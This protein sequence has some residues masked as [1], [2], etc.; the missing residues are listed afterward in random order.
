[1]D[2][3][4]TWQATLGELELT[5]SKA[6]F[7]T[8][9]KNTFISSLENGRVVISVPNTF[10]KAWL[11]KKYHEPIVKALRNVT[12]NGVREVTY[13]VEVRNTTPLQQFAD[14]IESNHQVEEAESFRVADPS[15]SVPS[16]TDIG[17]NPRYIFPSFVVGKANELAHAAAMAVAAKPGEAYNPL[18]IYGGSGLGKTHLLQAIGHH[19]LESNP[20]AKVLYVTS[21]RFTNE[22]IQAVR[23]GRGKEF[24]DM[25]RNVDVLLI[26]DIQF[27]AGKES[28]QEELFHTFNT[29]HQNNKQLVISSDRAPK[30]IQSL[31]TRMLTRF[32]WGMI[33]DVSAPDF[34]TRVAILEAKAREKNIQLNPEIL[35]YIAGTVQMNV[36][37]LEG[38]LNKII[39]YH[40]FKNTP[41]TMESVQSLLQSFVPNAPK[42]TI[43]PRRLIEIVVGYYDLSLEE[44]LGKS[45]EQRLAY[46]RQI[47][48]YLLREEAKCSFPAIGTQLGGRDHTT[49]MHACS[50]IS[51]LVKTDETLRRDIAMLREKLYATTG[52]NAST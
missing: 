42:R 29:L 11:E 19:V 2:L 32:E 49:A 23:G 17:L 25:Y 46:P 7:T 3:N 48:M 35:R 14:Q 41:A 5:L 28:T 6:N 13:R 4:E 27:I 1:M 24:K 8:W 44:I 12:S 34:E 22:F 40:Q 18:Y 31:E 26:D 21:E 10:T 36:R 52:A 37:E 20:N 15:S 33:T 45:R 51:G 9:F 39:A 47:A 16:H 38:A 43:T 50:K 30:D